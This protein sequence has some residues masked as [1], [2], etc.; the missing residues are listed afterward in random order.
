MQRVRARSL[1]F[2][3]AQGRDDVGWAGRFKPCH[4]RIARALSMPR[5]RFGHDKCGF[6][7][8]RHPRQRANR[9]QIYFAMALFNTAVENYVEKAEI[10]SVSHCA[11]YLCTACTTR[12]AGTFVVVVIIASAR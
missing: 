5:D 11:S 8:Q 1:P 9:A 12:S 6:R 4:Y 3:F 2:G 7:L 10:I